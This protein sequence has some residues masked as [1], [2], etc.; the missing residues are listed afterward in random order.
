MS[1]EALLAADE[2][3]INGV[4]SEVVD[5]RLSL[6]LN[7]ETIL[8]S[9]KKTVRPIADTSWELCGI[10]SEVGALAAEKAFSYLKL[11]I[12]RIALADC[13]APVSH[14]LEKV[15]YPSAS[16]LAKAAMAMLGKDGGTLGGI[17]RADTFKGPY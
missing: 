16:T 13:P 4:S 5:L 9:V 8:N 6:L 11:P 12:R 7:E 3:E 1:T 14:S 17:H 10:S 2:L 15:F